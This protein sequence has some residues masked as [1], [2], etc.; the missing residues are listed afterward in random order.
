MRGPV[1]VF[2]FSCG[3]TFVTACMVP[4]AVVPLTK[5]D[6]RNQVPSTGKLLA[7]CLVLQ[8]VEPTGP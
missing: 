5:D 2:A 3:L 8:A 7:R 1:R 6:V 4:L